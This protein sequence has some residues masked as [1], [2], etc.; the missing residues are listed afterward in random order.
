LDIYEAPFVDGRRQALVFIG[1]EPPEFTGR[2]VQ[3]RDVIIVQP[4]FHLRA[5]LPRKSGEIS[6][7]CYSAP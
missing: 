7:P 4:P 3:R 5:S 1:V 2:K 6:Y